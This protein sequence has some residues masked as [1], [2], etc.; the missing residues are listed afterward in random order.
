MPQNELGKWLHSHRKNVQLNQT[1]AAKKAGISRTQWARI[2]S[3]ES[4]TKRNLVPKLAKAVQAD[5]HETYRRAGY[6]P[7]SEELYLPSLI[8]DFDKLPS[9]VKEDI[10]VQIKA[11][12]QKYS[13]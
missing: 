7:P 12:R 8:E 4:G 2:E 6:V 9:R 10:A 1:Q 11:L 3:G 13:P 5:L